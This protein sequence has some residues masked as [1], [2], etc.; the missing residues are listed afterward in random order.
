MSTRTIHDVIGELTVIVDRAR[1][2]RSRIGYFAALY[3]NV[4]IRVRD[5]IRDGRFEDGDRM[6]R[7]DVLFAGR[8]LD[9]VNAYQAGREPSRSWSTA[10]RRVNSWP[11]LI[12]QHL[13]L[14]INA[15]IN[16]D[17]AIAAA[18]TAPGSELPGLKKDFM[19]IN[20]IL[21]EMLDD[22]QDRITSV[23]PWMGVL[24]RVGARTDEEICSFC[25]GRSRDVAWNAAIALNEA[26]RSARPTQIDLHDRAVTA[27]AIPIYNPGFYLRTALMGARLREANDPGRV[28]DVL[29]A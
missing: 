16:L 18:E 10:F 11:L 1:A 23:S 20:A 4:T 13:L 17:L 2:E 6:A 8:Y 26:P 12:V 7:L 27:L 15:H 28:I 22:V 21:G 9:A 14:G 5:G 3:R 19:A 25:L 29:T 24:D